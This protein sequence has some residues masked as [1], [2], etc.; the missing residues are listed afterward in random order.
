M[1]ICQ[2]TKMRLL[3][4]VMFIILCLMVLLFASGCEVLKSKRT[5]VKDSVAVAKSDSGAVT[6]TQTESKTD[7]EWWKTTLQ[8]MPQK[9][10]DTIINHNYYTNEMPQPSVVVIEGGKGSNQ[11]QVQVIDSSWRQAYDS[12]AFKLQE[13]SKS[14]ETTVMSPLQ[15]IGLCAGVCIVLFLLSKLKISVK[16]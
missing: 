12:L 8:Y 9:T 7:W 4:G 10:G 1:K 14:K 13:A 6:K 2:Q 15:I 5:V 16:K 3:W 11:T